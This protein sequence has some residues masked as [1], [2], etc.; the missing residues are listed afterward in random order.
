M[1]WNGK[2]YRQMEWKKVPTNGMEKSTDQMEWNGKM[3]TLPSLYFCVY[4]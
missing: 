4:L 3:F 2:K 1:E